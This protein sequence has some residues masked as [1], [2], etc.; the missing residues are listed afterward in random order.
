MDWLNYHHLYYFWSVV[1]EGGVSAA[2]RKLRLAQ[3]TISGQLKALEDSFGERLFTRAG[4]SLVL[5]EVGQ[6]VYRYADEIFSLGR[7]LQDTV[8]DRPTGRPRRLTVG[9]SDAVAKLIAFRLIEPALS[10]PE[11][12]RITVN[13]DRAERLLA[14]LATHTYDLVIADAPLGAGSPV[15]AFSHLLGES[16]VSFFATAKLAARLAPGFPQ[17]LQ[18]APLLVP[19]E[20]SAL[21]RTLAHWLEEQR[22][23]PEIVGDFQDNALLTTFGQAG[24]GVFPAPTVIEAEVRQQFGVELV[25]RVEELRE[26]FYAITVER[27]LKN[28]AVVAISEAARS[29]LFARRTPGG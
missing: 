2:A 23:R 4:R 5:T 11:R 25:G 13:E 3:P 15:R 22:L 24:L 20:N 29:E 1:K 9:V 6:V 26:R 21:E 10:L 14:S 16:P 8:K 12:V 27:R 7:E 19:G 17:S 18:G 28:P